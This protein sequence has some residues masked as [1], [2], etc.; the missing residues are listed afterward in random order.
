MTTKS[1]SRKQVIISISNHNKAKFM[2]SSSTHITNL[3]RALKN[4]KSEFMADFVCI[5]QTDI[6]IVINKVTLSFN[7]QT[8]KKYVKNTNLINLNKVNV[9]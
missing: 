1:S 5:D 3:D 6:I 7:L 8:I 9:P 4:I 2:E